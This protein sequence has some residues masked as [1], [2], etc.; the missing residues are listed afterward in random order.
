[1]AWIILDILSFLNTPLCGRINSY[2]C[3]AVRYETLKLE[4]MEIPIFK[5][6]A[7]ALLR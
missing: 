2:M 4:L 7:K 1:M 5:N 3:K 6:T